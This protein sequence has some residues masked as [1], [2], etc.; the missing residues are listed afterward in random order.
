MAAP[1][2]RLRFDAKRGLAFSAVFMDWAPTTLP[3]L[4]N[5]RPRLH[6]DAKPARPPE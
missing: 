4:R 6:A 2:Y 3:F 5:R 1:S